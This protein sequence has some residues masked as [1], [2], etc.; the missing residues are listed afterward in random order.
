MKKFLLLSAG[1]AIAAAATPAAAQ[2]VSGTVN[3]TGNVAGR[4]AVVAPGGSAVQ[5]FT[6]TIALDRLDE[7]DGTLKTALET[8]IAAASGGTPVETRVVCT[9]A[10]VAINVTA[11]TLANGDRGAPP[12]PGYANEINFT[13]ELQVALASGGTDQVTF[14]TAAASNGAFSKQVGRLAASGNNVTV[15]AYGFATKGGG[16]NLLAAGSYSSTINVLI[17]AVI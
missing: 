11:D 2:S 14:N 4:C 6:G 17:A 16:T 8:T 7:E 13:A 3:V 15:K 5:S 1:V 9:A 12:A 10:T